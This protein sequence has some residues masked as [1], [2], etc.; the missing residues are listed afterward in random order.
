MKKIKYIVLA[1]L[2]TVSL[3]LLF[4]HCSKGVDGYW[5]EIDIFVNNAPF[6]DQI[7]AEINRFSRGKMDITIR[8]PDNKRPSETLMFYKVPR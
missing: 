6:S 4:S 1:T 8:S 2:L 7:K 5:G 3:G